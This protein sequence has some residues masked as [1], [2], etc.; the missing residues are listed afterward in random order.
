M[1]N[2]LNNQ[3]TKLI[4]VPGSDL[5]AFFRLYFSFM[6]SNDL[7]DSKGTDGSIFYS[8]LLLLPT[9]KH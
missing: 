9:H 2:G 1:K 3:S 6:D 4:L 5:I 8:S 7:Q